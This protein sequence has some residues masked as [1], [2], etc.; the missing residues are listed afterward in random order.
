MTERKQ[1]PNFPNY[2]ITVEGNVTRRVERLANPKDK[3]DRTKET[4]Y[5][6]ISYMSRKVEPH[7][8]FVGEGGQKAVRKVSMIVDQVFGVQ[9]DGVVVKD[10]PDYLVS[11]EGVVYSTITSKELT[12][13]IAANGY[14]VVNLKTP[15]GKKK[16]INV[17]RLVAETFL[18]GHFEGAHVNHKDGNKLN[19][20]LD[21]LEWCTNQENRDHAWETGLMDS[22]LR[23]CKIS[24]NNSDW[25]YFNSL[26]E[27]RMYIEETVGCDMSNVSKLSK[28][29]KDNETEGK[30]NRGIPAKDNPFRCRGF[31]V[32]YV[33]ETGDLS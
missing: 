29:A 17:H 28:C 22:K 27:A 24:L 11:K 4:V 16:V 5:K 20:S 3:K 15:D 9:F 25:M 12:N 6:P 31:V 23:K 26:K 7:V 13:V 33:H 2:Y 14:Y 32:K 10:C 19:N 8:E 1:V 21:N 18:T 30:T